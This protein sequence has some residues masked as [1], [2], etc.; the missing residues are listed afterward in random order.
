MGRMTMR[1]F[2][3]LCAFLCLVPSTQAQ[4][5]TPPLVYIPQVL[6][7]YPHDGNAYT[8][9]LLYHDGKLYESTGKR[10]ESSLREVDLTTGTVLRQVDVTR[11]KLLNN[12]IF[13]QPDYF[14]E[15]L[16]LVDDKLIQLTWTEQQAFVYDLAT[17]EKTAT[18]SY[19]GQGW[20]ICSDGQYLYMSDSTS[21]LDLRDLNTF[22]LI[23]SFAVLYT[24]IDP[25]TNFA[26]Q[27]LIPAQ[28][29]NELECVGDT[30]Y[31]NLWNT[32][33]IAQIDK[34]NGN[35]L[36]LIDCTGLLTP[37]ETAQA[38]QRDSGATLNGIAYNPD[39]QTFYITGKMWD[40]LFE[41]VFVPRPV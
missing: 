12:T 32:D 35:V 16:A 19:E 13:T 11:S 21:Y 5:V 29:L 14:A 2:W 28:K 38:R 34:R 22:D 26:Q 20:G 31:A 3:L 17:F 15:G 1:Y 40:K 6:A 7:V 41:V 23:V 39:T 25:S 30:I 33:L 24:T 37:E 9:G 18:L 8:Q 10:G 4:I 36:A 27:T